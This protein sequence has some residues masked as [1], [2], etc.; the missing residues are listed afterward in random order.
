[1]SDAKEKARKRVKVRLE[2]MRRRR[3]RAKT[4]PVPL[5]SLY[6]KQEEIKLDARR[7]NVLDIGRRA[8]KTYLGVHLALEAA[9]KGRLVGW[10]SPTYKYLL[11]V[12]RDLERPSQIGRAHV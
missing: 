3:E 5:P 10:F 9:S 2:L 11:D 4:I 7:Y 6:A 12:W 1:M 8:G